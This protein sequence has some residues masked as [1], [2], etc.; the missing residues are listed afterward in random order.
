[1]SAG[2][3]FFVYSS[4]HVEEMWQVIVNPYL[5]R[6]HKLPTFFSADY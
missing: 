1:M 2:L 4:E 5:F 6:V 3:C